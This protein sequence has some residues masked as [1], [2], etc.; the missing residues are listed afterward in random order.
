ML[1]NITLSNI[2]LFVKDIN[3]A[4][5]FYTKALCLVENTKLSAVP[6]FILLNADAC[7]I[8]LQD[9]SA[10]GAATGKADSVELGFEVEDV[11]AARKRLL[12]WGVEVTEIQQMGWG[13]E[14]YA[15]DPDGHRPTIFRRL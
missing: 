11:E 13:G 5:L 7:K 4:K 10:P 9:S 12:E 2:N 1:T 3:S 8:T 14:F 15:T 6:S